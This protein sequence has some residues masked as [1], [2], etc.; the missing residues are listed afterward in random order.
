MYKLGVTA[1]VLT[2][3]ILLSAIYILFVSDIHM[4]LQ[5]TMFWH[6]TLMLTG[7]AFKIS[8]V[9][10]LTAEHRAKDSCLEV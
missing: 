9:L 7:L 1:M 10:V 6:F 4:S 3:C 5:W 8:Y 2:F